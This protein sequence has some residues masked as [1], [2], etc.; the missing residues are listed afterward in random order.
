[1][2]NCEV[3]KGSPTKGNFWSCWDLVTVVRW[4]RYTQLKFRTMFIFKKTPIGNVEDASHGFPWN[5][6]ICQFC[7]WQLTTFF[8]R[9]VMFLVARLFLADVLCPSLSWFLEELDCVGVQHSSG[10]VWGQ[11]IMLC[12]QY[13]FLVVGC[14]NS[15]SAHTNC[16]CHGFISNS[17]HFA[18]LAVC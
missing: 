4:V 9:I 5:W 17:C 6:N 1:M 12:D 16:R 10:I 3:P 14:C 7:E 11:L 2:S 8:Y 13:K 15:N 18:V